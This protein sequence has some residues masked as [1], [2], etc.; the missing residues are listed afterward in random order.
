MGWF[1]NNNHPLDKAT[2]D[3]HITVPS[4]H[5]ALG[6]G[7]LVSNPTA[8]GKTT[9]N[10]H[11]AYPM[12]TYLTTAT[13]GLFDYT[14]TTGATA[15][16]AYG[17]PLEL[18]NA[19]D[20]SYTDAQKAT[21]KANTTDREDQIVSFLSSYNGVPYPFDSTGAVVD[22][23][24]RRRLRARGPDQDPLPDQ[25]RLGQHA[26]ARERAPVVRR[27]RV[28]EAA[29]ATSGS[30]RAGR[31]GRSGTGRAASTAARRR[32]SSSTRPT[33]RPQQP[34]RWNTPTAS[35]TAAGL[36]STFPVYTRG[37]M[38]IEGLREIIGD[39]AFQA[40]IKT[41]LTEN[42]LRQRGHGGVR[43]HRQARS[44]ATS[45]GFDSTNLAKLDT[46]FQQWLYGAGKPTL[47]PT[48][49]FASTSV[50][51][52]SV[53]GSVPAT[54]ALSLGAPAAFGAFTPGVGDDLPVLD[55][56]QRDLDR[57]ATAR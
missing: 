43:R 23:I 12:A 35:P 52:V 42:Q 48:A 33:R 17:N 14:K 19:F 15:L 16:G 11:H 53:G 20:S 44:R 31:R 36:F 26:L 34:T 50:P 45:R 28:A 6:N 3:F 39:T 56:G 57:R 22:R 47:T 46:Y 9:W 40:L 2:Y 41:W 18:H 30:T 32:S 29:G 51:G 38:T 13:V 27:Q 54:L 21:L 55:D 49:F 25:Q 7:E 37:A 10:W 24:T 5:V 1:P 8:N 4:T